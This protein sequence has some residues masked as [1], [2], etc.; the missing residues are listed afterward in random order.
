MKI[1]VVSKD[2]IWA[3]RIWKW[4][5]LLFMSLTRALYIRDFLFAFSLE[6]RTKKKR[7]IEKEILIFFCQLWCFCWMWVCSAFQDVFFI[8]STLS[9]S[10]QKKTKK[11]SGWKSDSISKMAQKLK[12]NFNDQ[13]TLKIQ[14]SSS[15]FEALD[16]A[17]HS[18]HGDFRCANVQ[19]VDD[20]FVSDRS[21]WIKIVFIETNFRVTCSRQLLTFVTHVWRN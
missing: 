7:R 6:L 14:F 21:C 8:H 11:A 5:L 4:F 10:L 9:L 12:W 13:N 17:C 15:S 16:S 1:F 2:E 18:W 3:R 20:R 19:V